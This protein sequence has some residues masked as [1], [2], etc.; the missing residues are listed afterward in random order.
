VAVVKEETR[1]NIYSYADIAKRRGAPV[2]DTATHPHEVW[3][4]GRFDSRFSNVRTAIHTA[5]QRDGEIRGPV[6]MSYREIE[7]AVLD[8]TR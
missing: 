6:R 3:V 8:W 5:Y 4:N 7:R 1:V 2:L